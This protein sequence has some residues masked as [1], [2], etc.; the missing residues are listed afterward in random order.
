MKNTAVATLW[1]ETCFVLIG[2]IGA[3]MIADTSL[4]CP[5]RPRIERGDKEVDHDPDLRRGGAIRRANQVYAAQI[6]SAGVECDPLQFASPDCVGNDELGFVEDPETGDGNCDE[7][8]AVIGQHGSLYGNA[9]VAFLAE[10][11]FL[12]S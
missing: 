10:P 1:V 8:V 2:D 7:S 5:W 11:P 9:L 12:G 3:A 6:R 4:K